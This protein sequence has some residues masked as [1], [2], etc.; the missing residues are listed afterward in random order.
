MNRVLGTDRFAESCAGPA[1]VATKGVRLI[2]VGDRISRQDT[3]GLNIVGEVSILGIFV[4][5]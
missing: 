3:H 4:A 1:T 5:V 2:E